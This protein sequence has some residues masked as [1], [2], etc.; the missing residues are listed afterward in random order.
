M[1]DAT[2]IVTTTKARRFIVADEHQ[3][4][5]RIH[6]LTGDNNLGDVLLEIRRGSEQIY[7][8]LCCDQ[9][10]EIAAALIDSVRQHNAGE[11]ELTPHQSNALVVNV[12]QG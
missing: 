3:S 1:S 7:Q 5:V 6:P 12:E 2:R 10:L 11:S 8:W 9:A 4:Y